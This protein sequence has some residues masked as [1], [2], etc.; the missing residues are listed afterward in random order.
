MNLRTIGL[1]VVLVSASAA[2]A[3]EIRFR[4]VD[5][6]GGAIPG[7]ALELRSVNASPRVFSGVTDAQ[8]TL[9]V[10]A[11]LPLE[12]QVTAPGFDSLRQRVETTSGD[13]QLQLTPAI[14]RTTI[15]VVVHDA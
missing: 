5:P 6:R 4:V 7:A 11:D 13:V 2:V 15:D 1:L 14:V 8:G 9:T 3:Q 10:K 12:I